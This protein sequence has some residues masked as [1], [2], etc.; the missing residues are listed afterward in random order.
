MRTSSQQD[1]CP[2]PSPSGFAASFAHTDR[3]SSAHLLEWGINNHIF[4][5][6]LIQLLDRHCQ[7][8]TIYVASTGTAISTSRMSDLEYDTYIQWFIIMFATTIFVVDI[9]DLHVHISIVNGC[10]ISVFWIKIHLGMFNILTSITL[11]S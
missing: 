5:L 1:T 7:C 4:E 10:L 3:R 8:P 6:S 2:L 11:I 9:L